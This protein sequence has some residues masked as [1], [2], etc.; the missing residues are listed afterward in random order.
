[1][2]TERPLTALA[3][4]S[5]TRT[6]FWLGFLFDGAMF[7]TLLGLGISRSGVEAGIAALA[8]FGGLFVF[9]FVEYFFHRWLFHSWINVMVKGHKAHHDNP[10]GYDA[11]PFFVAS[12]VYLGI[13]FIIQLFM[14][15]E[16]ALLLAAG[17]VFGYITYGLT[18]FILHRYRFKSILG[19]KL[20][21]YHQ[22]HHY[23]PG[24][25]FGVTSPLWDIILGTRYQ[26][27]HRRMW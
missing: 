8:L 26:S 23:H 4:F 14:P 6:N 19:R 1:M 3:Q 17:F 10:L 13:A 9:S 12:L 18:H 2:I 21:A 22:I 16:Y 11:L 7:V 24:F 15:M 25:N 27:G 20:V 5:T